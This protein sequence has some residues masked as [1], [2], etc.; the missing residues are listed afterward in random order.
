M[1]WF[2]TLNTSCNTLILPTPAPTDVPLWSLTMKPHSP[3]IFL[4]VSPI[5][6]IHLQDIS[7]W[8]NYPKRIFVFDFY[9][10]F[11]VHYQ[12]IWLLSSVER[13]LSPVFTLFHASHHAHG[14]L[15]TNTFLSSFRERILIETCFVELSSIKDSR[16][17]SRFIASNISLTNL[18]L[19]K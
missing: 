15:T 6:K 17:S 7:W 10:A 3:F 19:R 5:I 4:Y 9:L 11:P 13:I 2:S 12:D 1:H 8:W 18:H 16:S 14:S